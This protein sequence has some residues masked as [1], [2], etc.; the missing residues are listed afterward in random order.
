MG[1]DGGF[2]LRLLFIRLFDPYSGS[3]RPAQGLGRLL[4]VDDAV[5]PTHSVMN[6][7]VREKTRTGPD[8]TEPAFS[9]PITDR[10]SQGPIQGQRQKQ[11]VPLTG[12]HSLTWTF[13][14]RKR[15]QMDWKAEPEPNNMLT[16][17]CSAL[18]A[19][20]PAQ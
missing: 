19:K 13:A 3:G 5:L 1:H 17:L 10:V 20:R 16:R 14:D 4:R 15:T 7:T 9:Q 18:K 11:A 12:P 8:R 2:A 6:R